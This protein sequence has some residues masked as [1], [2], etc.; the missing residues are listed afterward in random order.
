MVGDRPTRSSSRGE[1][2]DDVGLAASPRA[3][4]VGVDAG[5][6]RAAAG[7]PWP[8]ARTGRGRRRRRGTAGRRWPVV[9]TG[10]AAA[11]RTTA[12]QDRDQRDGRG[13]ASGPACP[14]PRPAADP[15][16]ARPVGRSAGPSN[17]PRTSSPTSG[18]S[19]TVSP[20]VAQPLGE[21]G[22]ARVDLAAR[23][24]P[25]PGSRRGPGGRCVTQSQTQST[26][27]QVPDDL[28]GA[29][30]GRVGVELHATASAQSGRTVG[31][32]RRL[33]GNVAPAAQF[34]RLTGETAA[35]PTSARPRS[36]PA[37]GGRR[38]AAG[39]AGCP[40]RCRG[41]WSRGP[42]SPAARSRSSRRCRP[43]RRSA[44]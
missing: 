16:S 38:S 12:A 30:Y 36:A 42:T 31:R 8:A 3:G 28:E 40:R 22:G 41:S 23:A 33:V 2:V 27:R 13:R 32:S 26:E 17:G 10:G 29:A 11:G 7:G 9:R 5:R 4:R 24:W 34:P 35:A 19:A 25:A 1:P 43:A 15:A 39:S 14:R 21:V 44:G 37:P 6:G 18:T 20:G